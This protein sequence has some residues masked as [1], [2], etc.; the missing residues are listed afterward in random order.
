[1]VLFTTKENAYWAIFYEVKKLL[2]K[3]MRTCVIVADS[4]QR[5]VTDKDVFKEIAQA[6]LLPRPNIYFK[7]IYEEEKKDLLGIQRYFDPENYVLDLDLLQFIE[8]SKKLIFPGVSK[9]LEDV[10]NHY[11][12]ISEMVERILDVKEEVG[13]LL[14]N[15]IENEFIRD[16]IEKFLNLVVVKEGNQIKDLLETFYVERELLQ[17]LKDEL[18]KEKSTKALPKD[19]ER[20]LE[21]TK[22]GIKAIDEVDKYLKQLVKARVDIQNLY[23]NS[24]KSI[25]KFYNEMLNRIKQNS[26]SSF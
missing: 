23:K 17:K 9:A 14:K 1:M 18:E 22:H 25:E 3:P 13:E 20:L 2:K 5:I 26:S 19:F 16:H 21:D 15:M 7:G 24:W 8:K 4:N 10:I 6:F 12:K 11:G